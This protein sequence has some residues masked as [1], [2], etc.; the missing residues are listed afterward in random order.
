MA[1]PRSPEPFNAPR[2]ATQPEGRS[3]HGR[4]GSDTETPTDAAPVHTGAINSPVR[5]SDTVMASTGQHSAASR[6]VSSAT[7]TSSR[8]SAWPSCVIRK[9]AET[10]AQ[11][12]DPMH[13][14][15]STDSRQ[16]SAAAGSPVTTAPAGISAH[17]PPCPSST[18]SPLH[19]QPLADAADGAAGRPAPLEAPAW[20]AAHP[21][22]GAHRARRRR[23][24]WE[25]CQGGHRDA[26]AH[27]GEHRHEQQHGPVPGAAKTSSAAV[28]APAAIRIN[29]A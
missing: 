14:A 3:L 27:P 6:A 25:T 9:W 19:R 21:G 24:G 16:R 18:R 1:H 22:S 8:G 17:G 23:A 4:R 7:M 28:H 26:A 2:D 5:V 20:P 13:S 10:P 11:A 12:P 29:A 15:V